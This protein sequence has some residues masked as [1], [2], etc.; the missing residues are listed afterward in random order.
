MQ[1]RR[2]FLFQCLAVLTAAPGLVSAED[3]DK[4]V[5]VYKSPT[6]GCCSKWVEHLRAAGFSVTA[7]DVAD[8]SEYK[9]RYGVPWQLGSCHTAVVGGY[10]IEGHVPAEDII[11]LLTDKPDILGLAVPGM[12]LGS[13]GMEAPNPERYETIAF[14]RSGNTVVFAVHDPGEKRN[15]K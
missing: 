13:P 7:T 4:S 8:I 5:M 10:V 15:R 11:R 9:L 14:D 3:D 12:P 6:C 1:H 2:T